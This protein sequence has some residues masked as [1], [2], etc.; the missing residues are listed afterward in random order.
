MD[1]IRLKELLSVFSKS[2]YK[3]IIQIL[4]RDQVR[5]HKEQNYHKR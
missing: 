2:E 4:H 5:Y 3:E 1:E